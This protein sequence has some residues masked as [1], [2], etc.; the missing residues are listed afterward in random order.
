MVKIIQLFELTT[1]HNYL[2][3]TKI[4]ISI[5]GVDYHGFNDKK[6]KARLT[7]ELFNNK[8][9]NKYYGNNSLRIIR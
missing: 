2:Y 6:G 4:I 3:Q 5:I 1:K 7:R 9:F 8:Y